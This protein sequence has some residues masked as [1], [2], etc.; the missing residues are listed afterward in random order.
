MY[1]HKLLVLFIGSF[2][3]LNKQKTPNQP[4][5]GFVGDLQAEWIPLGDVAS[6][7]SPPFGCNKTPV[8]N[9]INLV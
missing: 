6:G 5:Q 7:E 8:T 3:G 2:I 4:S 1:F 9:G